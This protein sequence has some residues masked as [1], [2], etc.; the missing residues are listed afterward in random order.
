MTCE[1]YRDLLV[2]FE[3]HELSESEETLLKKHLQSCDGCS[4]ELE[5]IRHFA[6]QMHKATTP[7]RESLKRITVPQSSKRPYSTLLSL[8]GVAAAFV[9]VA[10]F[11]Y[12]RFAAPNI[13]QLAS[14]GIQ[15]YVLVDQTHP[16]RG[17]A[18]AVQTW[19][20]DHHQISVRPPAQ[21]DYSKLTGCKVAQMNSE[22][23]ALL[24][25]EE[26][27]VKALFILPQKSIWPVRQKVID[28]DGFRIEFWKEE[29]TLYM[30]LKRI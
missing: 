23:V 21:V 27:P 14:W 22:A 17:N 4:K 10:A 28:K 12:I 18:E 8:G 26:K 3:D 25:L 7:F 5:A 20:Q 13:E 16:I 19:F 30:S 24:R 1:D 15:H 2:A 9:L 6:H 29:G 11:F